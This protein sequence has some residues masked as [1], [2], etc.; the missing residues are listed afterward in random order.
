MANGSRSARRLRFRRALL[1]SG[2]ALVIGFA[3]AQSGG[4]NDYEAYGDSDAAVPG[5][6][7][8]GSSTNPGS[9]GSSTSGTGNTTSSTGGTA[10]NG[11]GGAGPVE[12]PYTCQILGNVTTPA[13]AGNNNNIKVDQFGYLPRGQKVAVVSQ[14]RT[15]YN[16]TESFE[17]G[18]TMELRRSSDSAVVFSGA[19]V[20]WN[21]G[22]VHTQSGDKAWWFDFTEY[23]TAGRYHVYDPKNSARSHDFAIDDRVYMGPL[24]A[25]VRTFYYQRCGVA[26]QSQHAGAKWSDGNACHT[27]D[28]SSRLIT[29]QG[30]S[31]T[32]R[33]LSGG[34]HDAGDFTKYTN[35]AETPV[36]H[37]IDA[38]EHNPTIWTDDFGIPESGNGVPDILDE[39]KVELDWLLKMQESN[40]SGLMKIG[41]T[42]NNCASP[43]SNDN[44][45]RYY[46]PA[47]ASAT[48]A[49]ASSFARAAVVYKKVPQLAAFGSTLEAAAV[50]AWTWLA[51]NPA[52]STY[53]NS[54]FGSADPEKTPYY[55]DVSKLAAAVYLFA[56]TGNT[57]YRDFVDTNLV[58]IELI[59][60]YWASPFD[61]IAINSLLYYASLPNAT[62][63]RK[64]L[65]HDRFRK[66][67][68]SNEYFTAHLQNTD[69]YRAFLKDDDYVWGSNKAK[70]EKGSYYANMALYGVDA[71][72]GP[73]YRAVGANFLNYIHGVNPNGLAYVTN[74]REYG[75][76][77]S[78]NEI[79]HCWFHDGSAWDSAKSGNGPAPG[80][81]AGGP[82]REYRPAEGTLAPPQ[83]QPPQKAYRDWNTSYPQNSWEVT[84]P[85]IYYQA[86]YVKLLAQYVPACL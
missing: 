28:K 81:L 18:A 15:G 50:K 48:G 72:N 63:A 66:A 27:Q 30:N 22:N 6:G 54:G 52:Y 14:A 53:N 74:M 69:A 84:E 58:K 73:K 7:S 44:Q 3:C 49:L 64:I 36:H 46:G 4:Q 1:A 60:S 40:G 41:T 76:E 29:D 43:P 77:N 56:L 75:A 12:E 68:A 5:D 34:W 35:F 33:D 2:T 62:E 71:Q 20:A 10:Q 16:A 57:S 38:Y 37:L 8:G 55:Q 24:K 45:A 83:N 11:T 85:G 21:S 42:G 80:F 13:A 39:V 86:A 32:A 31:G 51:A 26:K 82:N 19:A 17:P 65:I 79:Y 78:A 67:M 25:A 59:K 61:S 23:T 9:G 70:S 47:Q